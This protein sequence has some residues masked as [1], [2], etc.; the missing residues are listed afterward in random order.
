MK[1]KTYLLASIFRNIA[2]QRTGVGT[3]KETFDA[4]V[5]LDQLYE[6]IDCFLARLAAVIVVTMLQATSHGDL[7]AIEVNLDINNLNGASRSYVVENPATS[8]GF[9]KRNGHMTYARWKK[10]ETEI[11]NSTDGICNTEMRYE[12]E[13]HL[14]KVVRIM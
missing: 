12:I 2:G 5:D 13:S 7:G 1:K 10:L 8:L 9:D 4:D 3:V 11:A 14:S 6:N